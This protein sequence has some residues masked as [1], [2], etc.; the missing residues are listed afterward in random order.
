MRRLILSLF[1][2]ALSLSV[3]SQTYMLRDKWVDCGNGCQ[4]LDPYYSEGVTFSWKGPSKGGKADG[5]GTAIKYVNGEYESTYVGEYKNG[6]REGK[7]KFTH[8]DGSTKTGTF[9]NGQLMGF[10]TMDAEDGSSFEGN[11]INYR[12]HGKGKMRWGNG[13]VFEGFIVSDTPYSGKFTNYDGSVIYISKGV[14][15]PKDS[16]KEK[17]TG[18]SPKIGIRQREYFD[19]DW[20]RCQPK[21]AAFY[22]IV[23]YEAP[24]KPKGVVKDY[25]ISGKLQGEATFVYIDYDDEGKNFNEGK[26]TLYHENGKVKS[27]NYYFNNKP[28]GPFTE[29]YESGKKQVEGSYNFGSLEGSVITY[30]ENGKPYTINIYENGELKNNKYLAFSEDGENCF[31]VYNEDFVKNSNNW[32]YNGPNGSLVIDSDNTIN[33]TV[34]PERN[35]T[36][37][38]YADFS[39][40]VNNIIDITTFRNPEEK[41]L[42]MCFLFGFK[43]WDNFCG[44]FINDNQFKYRQVHNGIESFDS[45]WQVVNSIKQDINTIR[46]VN[47]RDKVVF[48]INGEG[49]G[50]IDR[51]RYDGGYF[52]LTVINQDSKEV[53]M[54]AGGLSITELVSNL[55]S[56]KEYLPSSAPTSSDG[57]WKGNGSG[58]FVNEKGYIA[59]NY[60][61]VDGAKAIEVTFIRNGEAENYPA[62]VVMSDKQNDLAIIK[63]D[64]PSF[65]PMPTIPYNFS[66][67]IKD[68]GSEVF[69]LGYPIAD[70]MGEE[71]KFTDGKISSKTGIQGDVTVYQISVPIQPGNSGGPLFDNQGNLVGI[72]SSGLNRDY[73][74]SEN[75]NYAIKSSY[76]KSLIDSLPYQ[77]E[78]QTQSDISSKPLTEKIKLFQSYMTYI[79]IK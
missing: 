73:F 21:D 76:L 42:V 1:I 18:Y 67:R 53:T 52:G 14:A 46:I 29:Y 9:I 4:L 57:G 34:T 10:G 2:A 78:L 12:F 23:T 32:K 55:E 15:M 74:K 30:H 7:G 25:Y 24:N 20:N 27:E 61:V 56:V 43:D 41:D 75:V 71:V 58:F 63:I 62:S 51:P 8:K 5:F 33:Y 59:T 77:I 39:P 47:I 60:H 35:V 70:V 50:S 64:S 44:L 45:D 19:E 37:A 69:T 36:G 3:F 49:I 13:S 17:R 40:S 31:L 28:N 22:R 66:T 79:K 72:T 6:I 11:F 48:E 38:M 16:I 65:Q 54:S 68:T 26:K